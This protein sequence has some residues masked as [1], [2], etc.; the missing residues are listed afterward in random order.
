M[1]ITPEMILRGYQ[2]NTASLEDMLYVKGKVAIVTGG[3][4][5]LGFCVARRLCQGGA[6]VVIASSTEEKGALA[7]K[8][9]Q[10]EGFDVVYC[11]CDVRN[12]DEVKHL[13]AFT[14]ETFGSIDILVTAAGIWSFAHIGDLEESVFKDTLDI[15][16]L[17]AYRCAK[18][19]STYMIEHNI[20]GK[21]LLVSSNS[22][23][24]PQPV[25]GGYAHYTASKGGVIAMTT[26]LA[27]EL[28]RYGIMVNTVAPGGMFT[29]GC[30]TNG[31]VSTLS[32]EKKMEI[33][34]EMMVAKLDEIPTADSVA[35]V[36]YG[37][38]T[39]MADG[40]TGEC[41]VADSGMMRN[42]MAFQ[43]AIEQYPPAK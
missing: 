34:K 14:A 25:F 16:L 23:Y 4:S 19:V 37:M 12:E 9:F 32:N 11:K 28:K 17:G 31:P 22:A 26:E 15:N 30:L 13:V 1:N 10:E 29:P 42:I 35:I 41:I 33:G 38:C 5:G 40:V 2:A 8:L 3:T 27:K 36:V 20:K 21:L 18:Y 6:K 39:R 7:L 24:L 43:P